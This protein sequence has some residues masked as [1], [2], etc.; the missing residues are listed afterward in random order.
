MINRRVLMRGAASAGLMLGAGTLTRRAYAQPQGPKPDKLVV[1]ISSS[2]ADVISIFGREWTDRTG[3]PVEAVSQS[4]DTTYTKIVTSLAGGAPTDVVICDTVWMGAFVNAGFLKP[5]D[6]YIAPIEEELVPVA[7]NQ[8]RI[9][10]A[11]YAMP[12]SNE[13]KFLYYNE[14]A[15]ERAGLSDVPASWEELAE[16]TPRLRE[17]GVRHPTIWGWQQAEGLIC[18]YALLVNAFGGAIASDAGVWLKDREACAGALQLMADQLRDGIADPASTSLNDRQVVDS[19][20]AGQHAFLLSWA[21]LFS[22]LD[23]PSTSSIA[24]KVKVGLIPGV[25]AAGTRSSTVTGGSA[26][27][28]ASTSAHEEWAWDFINFI[29]DRKHQISIYDIRS[30]VPVWNDLYA[31]EAVAARFPY[32]TTMREQFDYAIWRPNTAKYAEQSAV[33]QRFVHRAINGDLAP[34]AAVDQAAEAIAAI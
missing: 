13:G 29:S 7:V 18:D 34:E 14:E 17:A 26:F 33:L 8:R 4:Y 9:D 24:G 20:G 3:I 1:I 6:A 32:I 15:L 10:G 27:A 11:I 31:S 19:F 28:I 2:Y 22:V 30:N 25:A 12:F 5:L 21:G 16:V 23:N